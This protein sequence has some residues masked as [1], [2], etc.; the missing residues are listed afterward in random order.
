M[1]RNDVYQHFI[2]PKILLTLN[3]FASMALRFGSGAQI[4]QA[5]FLLL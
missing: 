5:Y 4:G 3:Y 2:V 1:Y